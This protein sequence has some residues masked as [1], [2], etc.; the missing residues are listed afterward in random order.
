VFDSQRPQ[1]LSETERLVLIKDPALTRLFHVTRPLRDCDRRTE[2]GAMAAG[3][4]LSVLLL[5]GP[6]PLPEAEV[7]RRYRAATPRPLR[8]SVAGRAA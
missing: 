1:T 5:T 7:A 3:L 4:A 6:L 2:I 8:A